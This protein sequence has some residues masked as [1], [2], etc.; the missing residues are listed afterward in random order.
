MIDMTNNRVPY[1]LLTDEEKAVRDLEAKLAECLE[2]NALL[3]A[4]LGKAVEGLNYCINAPFSGWTIAQG[5]ARAML[6]EIRRTSNG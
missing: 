2:R 3:E 6:A 4:R 1:D 5:Y